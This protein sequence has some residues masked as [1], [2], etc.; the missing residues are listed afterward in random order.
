MIEDDLVRLNGLRIKPDESSVKIFD[1]LGIEN[2]SLAAINLLRRPEIN[3]ST[4]AE[5]L[6]NGHLSQ[7]IMEEIENQIKYSGYIERQDQLIK[8]FLRLENL[9][10]PREID[11]SK[12]RGLRREAQEKLIQIR[13]VSLGQA[14]RIAGV[15]PADISVLM[16][17]LHSCSHSA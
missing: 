3:Y 10:I 17:Y 15:N 8:K 5:I 6:G 11:F 4:I 13:P 7:E 12:I 1:Q 9:S 14:S 16:V 2:K